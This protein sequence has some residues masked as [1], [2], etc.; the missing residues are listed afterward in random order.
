MLID[1][2]VDLLVVD[3]DVVVWIGNLVDLMMIVCELVLNYCVLCVLLGYF[4]V[5]GWLVYLVEFC[6]Y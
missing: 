5:Y 1:M 2:V 3:I 6:V 4:V